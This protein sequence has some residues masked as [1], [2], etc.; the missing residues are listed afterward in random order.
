MIDAKLLVTYP[1]DT[2]VLVPPLVLLGVWIPRGGDNGRFPLEV[3]ANRGTKLTVDIL[4]KN[5]ADVGDGSAYS[6]ATSMVFDETIG[7]TTQEWLGFKELVRFRFTLEPGKSLE[8]GEWGW[9][10]FR[11]LRPV[12]FESVKA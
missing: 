2:T 3:V 1:V 12:W 11:F 10:L 5:R 4:E 9:I 7:R 8:D 6:P